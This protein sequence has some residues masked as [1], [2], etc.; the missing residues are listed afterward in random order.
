MLW[1]YFVKASPDMMEGRVVVWVEIEA[2]H[3]Q[4]MINTVIS[5]CQ[6]LV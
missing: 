3:S 1:V 4:G 2:A 6:K 5:S